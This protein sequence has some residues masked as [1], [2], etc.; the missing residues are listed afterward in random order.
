MEF[1]KFSDF[2][3]ES[4]KEEAVEEEF[5]HDKLLKE[6]DEYAKFFAQKLAAWKVE[7]PNELDDEKKAEFFSQIKDEWKGS[8]E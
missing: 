1:L 5:N 8:G 3:N 2:V 6:D 7:S 4:Q